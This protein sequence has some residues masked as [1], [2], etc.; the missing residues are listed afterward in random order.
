MPAIHVANTSLQSNASLNALPGVWNDNVY[1][2]NPP[3]G[4]LCSHER[5]KQA[6]I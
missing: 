2:R 3:H 4:A 5:L 6:L 1:H